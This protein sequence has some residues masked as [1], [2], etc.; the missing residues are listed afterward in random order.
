MRVVYTKDTITVL[1]TLN[2][3]IGHDFLKVEMTTHRKYVLKEQVRRWF[4]KTVVRVNIYDNKIIVHENYWNTH[5]EV[6]KRLAVAVENTHS[7]IKSITIEVR[8]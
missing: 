6:I 2:N 8:P 7:T 5:K 1:Q 3:A 4:W